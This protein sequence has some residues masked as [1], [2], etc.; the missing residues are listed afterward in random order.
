ML[1]RTSGVFS[2][3]SPPPLLLQ[4]DERVLFQR[5]Q[6]FLQHQA[7]LSVVLPRCCP[8][9]FVVREVLT[10]RGDGVVPPGCTAR[11]AIFP[12]SA[13]AAVHISCQ[14]AVNSLRTRP[15][16]A[17]LGGTGSPRPAAL[18]LPPLQDLS[19]PGRHP[20]AFL[21]GLLAEDA[22]FSPARHRG[23]FLLEEMKRRGSGCVA[24]WPQSGAAIK[25][26]FGSDCTCSTDHRSLTHIPL[27]SPS[28]F[29]Q[30]DSLSPHSP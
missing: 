21:A 22:Y 3:L 12:G 1:D 29:S 27:S 8:C 17:C 11:S 15:A 10:G 13:A 4:L 28:V 26:V 6:A 23:G 24:V 5:A 30:A 14:L 18:R 16:G 9:L 19:L 20:R 25:P 7:L 2:V